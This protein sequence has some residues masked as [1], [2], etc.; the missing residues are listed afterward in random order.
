MDRRLDDHCKT[1][2]LWQEAHLRE[3]E[4][5]AEQVRLAREVL[6]IRLDALNEWK[7][8]SIEDRLNF[9]TK[10]E[11]ES[12]H[13]ALELAARGMADKQELML[14]AK[15]AESRSEL[16]MLRQKQDANALWIRNLMI[17]VILLLIGVT[18]DLVVMLVNWR[19]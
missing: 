10:A 18:I 6:E 1:N 7:D 15:S 9:I 16:E 12:K 2:G 14:G 4:H 19:M 8:R 17:A 13:H 11:Y 5:M 3:H